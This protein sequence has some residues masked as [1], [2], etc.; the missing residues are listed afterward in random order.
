MKHGQKKNTPK[1]DVSQQAGFFCHIHAQALVDMPPDVVYDVLTHPDNHI[2]FQSQKV[3]HPALAP[4]TA[5]S[6][7][8]YVPTRTDTCNVPLSCPAPLFR[9]GS[10]CRCRGDP[11]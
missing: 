4:H 5:A 8:R 1:V 2:I 10:H 6:T 3:R 7:P 11:W 9:A